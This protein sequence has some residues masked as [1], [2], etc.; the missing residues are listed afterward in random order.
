MRPIGDDSPPDIGTRPL[1]LVKEYEKTTPAGRFV[2]EMGV[3]TNGEDIVWVS[4]DLAVSMHR[5]RKVKESEHR[6]DRL[7]S[8][9]TSDNRISYGCINMPPKFYETVLRP[10]V[11]KYGAI[12]YVIP[13]V[14][15]IQK[16]L[17]AYDVTSAP[18][19]AQAP[20][21]PTAVRAS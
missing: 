5:L 18:K 12:V 19:V 3:N 4:Y 13:E 1:H 10:T 6:Y 20:A 2:A 17:G 11:K 21:A 16:V 7:M 14:K 15:S 8:P 9:T